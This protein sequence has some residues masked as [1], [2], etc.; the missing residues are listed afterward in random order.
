MKARICLHELRMHWRSKAFWFL[1]PLA[2]LLTL[3]IML[4]SWSE[5]R[6]FQSSQVRWQQLN[7]Q[8]WEDQPDRH[9][10]R[11]A[12]YGSLV[13]RNPSLLS[14]IDPGVDHATGSAIF[15]EAH[16]Q[17][18][19]S[20]TR[21]TQ[22]QAFLRFGSLSAATIILILWPLVLIVLGFGTVSQERESGTLKILESLGVRLS[23]LFI[24]KA[25]AYLVLSLGLLLSVFLVGAIS[26]GSLQGSVSSHEM[27][28]LLLLFGLYLIY[29]GLWS[30]AILAVSWFTQTP[31]QSLMLLLAL[32][33]GLVVILP[34]FLTAT[35]ESIHPYPNRTAFDILIEQDI[36]RQGDSHDPNDPHFDEFKRKTLEKYGVE[37]V[38]DLPVNWNGLVMAEGERL[39]GE[40][41]NEHYKNLQDIFTRQKSLIAFFQPL[42]PYLAMRELSARIAGSNAA[43]FN[44]FEQAAEAYRYR[45]IQELN[46][47]HTEQIHLKDDRTQKVRRDEWKRFEAFS[48]ESPSL[49]WSLQG[50]LASFIS[51]ALWIL[52]SIIFLNGLV[53][54]WWRNVT[55]HG[56]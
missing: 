8:L 18:S 31:R 7:N 13:F 54:R 29:C 12:H 15:L 56:L 41:F 2:W 38:E 17:N 22:S 45:I 5:L 33:L 25:L 35:V 14:F 34:R 6:D 47:L 43:H 49:D 32:W 10:H 48:Y 16:R 53:I 3:L 44:H 23:D 51:L 55:N 11:V 19:A 37:K 52:L 36:V 42:N 9:P 46:A 4:A 1:F 27:I 24:G 20:F 26:L 40:V 50:S 21:S 39:G 28:R 30:V